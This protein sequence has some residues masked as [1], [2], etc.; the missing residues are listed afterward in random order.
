MPNNLIDRLRSAANAIDDTGDVELRKLLADAAEEMERLEFSSRH[1]ADMYRQMD[2]A[3]KVALEEVE[4]LK[5]Q[6]ERLREALWQALQG[7]EYDG[8]SDEHGSVYLECDKRVKES[9]AQSLAEIQAQA[10]ES[11]VTN[12]EV[13]GADG[14]PWARYVLVPDGYAL[15]PI[16][17]T[18]GMTFIGQ[19]MRYESLNSIGAIYKAMIAAAQEDTQ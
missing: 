18:D 19:S 3:R 7:W 6:N 10:V 2:D 16:E 17:P 13:D 4:Q 9:P 15:V 1:N 11:T 12:S 8:I 5:A 14:K